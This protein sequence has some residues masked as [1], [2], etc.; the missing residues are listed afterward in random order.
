[1]K[2][3]IAGVVLG[4]VL[5]GIFIWIDVSNP[6]EL[7]RVYSRLAVYDKS[8]QASIPLQGSFSLRKEGRTIFWSADGEL[9]Q[10]LQVLPNHQAELEVQFCPPDLNDQA[11]PFSACEWETTIVVPFAD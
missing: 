7:V 5:F 11:D 8:G 1:M 6:D 2:L 4:L 10:E 3:I 9:E